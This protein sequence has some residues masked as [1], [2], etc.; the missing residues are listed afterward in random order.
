MDH[1]QAIQERDAMMNQV[2]REL[3]EVQEAKKRTEIEL[4]LQKQ[5]TADLKV[6]HRLSYSKPKVM[7]SPS[8]MREIEIPVGESDQMLGE[9]D[10]ERVDQ[11][12][13]ASSLTARDLFS[14]K[15]QVNKDN[16]LRG[17]PGTAVQHTPRVLVIPVVHG[18]DDDGTN[19]Q[20]KVPGVFEVT[21]TENERRAR[22]QSPISVG[23]HY[24]KTTYRASTISICSCHPSSP[25]CRNSVRFKIQRKP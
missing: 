11:A 15:K 18:P 3:V 10:N 25:P 6:A 5:T 7:L 9:I 19:V 1:D 16:F 2:H 21:R 20:S 17:G 24:G 8:E 22:F 13:E 23:K 4:N 14:A 12:H